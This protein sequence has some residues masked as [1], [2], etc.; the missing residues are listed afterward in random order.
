MRLPILGEG[1]K[2]GTGIALGAAVVLLAPV[3]APAVA[4]ILKSIAKAGI[5]GGLILYEKGKVLAEEAKESMEDLAAEARAE[6][7]GEPEKAVVKTRKAAA[8]AK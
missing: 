8:A 1:M 5:K 3:V 4:G 2:L 7:S 6:M